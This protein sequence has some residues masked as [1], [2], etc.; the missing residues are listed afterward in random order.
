VSDTN[1]LETHADGRRRP[2]SAIWACAV[3][4]GVLAL[5]VVLVAYRAN[6]FYSAVTDTKELPRA[7]IESIGQFK[8][9]PGAADIQSHY[10]S[11]LDFTLDV[12]F[13]IPPNEV[14]ELIASTRIRRPLSTTRIPAPFGGD[15]AG[16]AV[17][18][19][20]RHFEAGESEP[21]PES[22]STAP[23]VR[24]AADV[25]P[26]AGPRR[27]ATRPA[28]RPAVQQFIVIDKTDPHA[29]KVSLHVRG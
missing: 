11:W 26:D 21:E 15:A 2:A 8:F 9:P 6:P 25:V 3:V 27:S 13:T 22:A 18:A 19:G 4:L 17:P 5:L 24:A 1:P 16:G 12:R 23:D 20:L 14:D 29:Y 10:L 28:T 7:S